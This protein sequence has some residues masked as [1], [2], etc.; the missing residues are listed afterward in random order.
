[1]RREP[2]MKKSSSAA[3]RVVHVRVRACMR[4]HEDANGEDVLIRQKSRQE[5]DCMPRRTFFL[6]CT[7]GMQHF[8]CFF[9]RI[10]ACILRPSTPLERS[11]MESTAIAWLNNGG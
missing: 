2:A 8:Y 5:E 3:T 10:L 7:H 9:Q 11:E 4:A 1:M 6:A